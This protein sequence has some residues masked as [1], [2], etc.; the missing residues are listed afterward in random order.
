MIAIPNSLQRLA[1]P[2]SSCS[3]YECDIMQ[4]T[5][6]SESSED[7]KS[8]DCRP[9]PRSVV[10]IRLIPGR[11]DAKPAGLG[12]SADSVETPLAAVVPPLGEQLSTSVV[13][14]GS[15][16]GGFVQLGSI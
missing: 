13:N 4:P 10:A 2:A 8:V 12:G 16:A 14:R 7:A 3:A 6:R 5:N 11:C 1:R 15:A 9:T